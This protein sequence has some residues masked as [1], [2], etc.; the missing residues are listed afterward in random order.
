[1]SLVVTGYEEGGAGHWQPV[2][3]ADPVLNQARRAKEDWLLC[4][5]SAMGLRVPAASDILPSS[6]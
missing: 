1:M 3:R 4:R 2:R 6:P 5:L